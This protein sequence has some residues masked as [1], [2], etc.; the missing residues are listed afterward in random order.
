M[1]CPIGNAI[2]FRMTTD[3]VVPADGLACW[4]AEGRALRPRSGATVEKP[5]GLCRRAFGFPAQNGMSSS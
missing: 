5:G 1:K 2:T 3:S 4:T